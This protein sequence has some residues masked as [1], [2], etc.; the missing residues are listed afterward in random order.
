MT[1]EFKEAV[2]AL[3]AARR[4]TRRADRAVSAASA[5]LRQTERD[6]GEACQGTKRA[7]DAVRDAA[8]AA[9][10]N[11]DGIAQ[12]IM[13]NRGVVIYWDDCITTT[14]AAHLKRAKGETP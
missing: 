4:K 5:R 11:P 6:Y 9:L 12:I 8:R 13:Q 14:W 1:S 2:K 3:G 7:A 10:G